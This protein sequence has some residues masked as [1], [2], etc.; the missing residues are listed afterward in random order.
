MESKIQYFVIQNED[1]KFLCIDMNS[2]GYPCF[3]DDFEHCERYP[4]ETAADEFLNS[5]YAKELFPHKLKNVMLRR[6]LLTLE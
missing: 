6:V 5:Y 2:G 1:G 4:S 3:V